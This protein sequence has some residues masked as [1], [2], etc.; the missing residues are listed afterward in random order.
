MNIGTPGEPVPQAAV[1]D[2]RKVWAY[3]Q[4]VKARHPGQLVAVRG[5]VFAG[6]LTPEANL[7]AIGYRYAV[8]SIL[9]RITQRRWSGAH[10]GEGSL[11]AAARMELTWVEVGA[12]HSAAPI[13]VS[14]LRERVKVA[15]A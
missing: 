10:V 13:V 9:E 1:E 14:F 4:E 12:V 2:L 5:N 11:R 7:H 15:F 6:A 8:L 3:Y